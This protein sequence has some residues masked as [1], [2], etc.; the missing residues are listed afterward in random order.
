[1]QTI[2]QPTRRAEF[3]NGVKATIPL[4]IGGI[5]FGVIFGALAISSGISPMGAMGMSAFVFAGSA[6]FIAV[7]LVAAGT[8]IWWIILTTFVVNA[9]HALYAVTLAPYVKHLPHRWLLPLGFMLTDEVFVVAITRYQQSDDSVNKHWYFFGSAVSMY[10]C[11]QISTLVGIVAGSAIPD[12]SSW[13]LDFALVVTFIGMLVPMIK[14][15]PTVTAVVVAS[16]T[17]LLTYSL[18][19]QLYLIVAAIA[20]VLAGVIAES[21]LPRQPEDEEPL[22]AERSIGP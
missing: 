8:G 21:L 18:P 5:P 1:M 22:A 17:A 4:E 12:M 14:N 16:A 6:Q 19:N 11:W 10:V 13:G 3:F 7:G 15:R 20:G 9:R 2:P